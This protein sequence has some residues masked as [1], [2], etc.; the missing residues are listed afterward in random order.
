MTDNELYHYG[1]LGMKWGVRR[2]QNKDGTRTTAGKKRYFGKDGSGKSTKPEIIEKR[3]KKILSSRS[4]KMLYDNADLF[5]DSELQSA[6]N[7]LSLER[8]IKSLDSTDVNKGKGFVDRALDK[9]V[10]LATAMTTAMTIWNTGAKFYNTF[11]KNAKEKPLPIIG[12]KE[13][14]KDE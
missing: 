14:K 11:A 1:I 8:N 5:S 6:Y 13:K 3:K 9:A 7:R 12:G 10:K 2:Y 4:A